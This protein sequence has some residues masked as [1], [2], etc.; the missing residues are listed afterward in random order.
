MYLNDQEIIYGNYKK[1]IEVELSRIDFL[2]LEN[3]RTN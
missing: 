2:V 3:R 1:N